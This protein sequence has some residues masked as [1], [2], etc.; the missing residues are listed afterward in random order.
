[1]ELRAAGDSAEGWVQE[2]LAKHEGPLTHYATRLLRGDR[3][4]A[5]DAVQETFARL[6]RQDAG[7]TIPHLAEWLF[8][9]CRR[10]AIDIRRKEQRMNPLSDTLA[11]RQASCD[12]SPPQVAENAETLSEV[13]RAMSG[14]SDA[15][16]ECLRLKFQHGFSY[17]EIAG[18]TGMTVS[19][20]GVQIHLGIKQLRERLGVSTATFATRGV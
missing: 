7:Q 19:S 12:P 4:R 1:M 8:T 6:C 20:V 5:R 10:I 14:L 9:V 17:R 2:A 11:E 16:Q 13:L 3:E 18:V 15:Q